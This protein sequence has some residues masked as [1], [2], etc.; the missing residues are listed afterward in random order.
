M[1]VTGRKEA[2]ARIELEESLRERSHRSQSR[3]RV[4]AARRRQPCEKP[5]LPTPRQVCKGPPSLP[6]QFSDLKAEGHRARPRRHQGKASDLHTGH[7]LSFWTGLFTSDIYQESDSEV[8]QALLPCTEWQRDIG[9][10]QALSSQ[11]NPI[12]EEWFSLSV[13]VTWILLL[14]QSHWSLLYCDGKVSSRPTSP[15]GTPWYQSLN[16]WLCYK[17]ATFCFANVQTYEL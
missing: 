6:T 8:L 15:Q 2:E 11:H 3:S 12:T 13:S 1:G 14:H 17:T 9:D 16:P 7:G 10:S 5:W 4:L